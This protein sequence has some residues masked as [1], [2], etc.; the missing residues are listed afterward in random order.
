MATARTLGRL[1]AG[2]HDAPHM[3][4]ALARRYWR[5]LGDA[6]TVLD[7]GCGAGDLGRTRPHP[8]ID[9]YGVDRDPV[10]RE[11]A[12]LYER[13]FAVDLDREPLPFAEAMFDGVLAKDILEHVDDPL[14]VARE[15]HRVLRP[16]GVFVASLVMARPSR[17]W[18]DYTHRRGFT[19]RSARRL[20]ED[21]GF[22]VEA[23]WRM[24]GV[25]GS[26]RLGFIDAVPTLL[27][28]PVFDALW[29]ASWELKAVRR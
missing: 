13:S 18:D 14:A 9:V 25:P 6:R 16:G 4:D 19:A 29:G 17:L 23:L 24:G 22:V 12:S 3:P 8:G 26:A 28:V 27:R 2:H 21:A 1:A 11:R 20:L 5:L 7:L 10:A 15:G